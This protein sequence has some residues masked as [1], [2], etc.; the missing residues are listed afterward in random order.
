V[1]KTDRQFVALPLVFLW[2]VGVHDVTKELL[3]FVSYT[4]F[5]VDAELAWVRW[6]LHSDSHAV[7]LI[8]FLLEQVVVLEATV[9][10]VVLKLEAMPFSYKLC[11]HSQK[12]LL[13]VV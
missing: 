6:R 2:V 7:E 8:E 4:D 11:C 3:V 9:H 10:H 13:F 1:K 5:D 12:P